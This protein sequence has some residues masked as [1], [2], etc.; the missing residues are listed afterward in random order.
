MYR[1]PSPASILNRALLRLEKKVATEMASADQDLDHYDP[2]P[3][4]PLITVQ[5]AE[6]MMPG[7]QQAAVK[8]TEANQ[9]NLQLHALDDAESQGANDL[10]RFFEEHPDATARVTLLMQE[11]MRVKELELAT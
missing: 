4:Y 6:T 11:L 9:G 2:D 7:L 8:A 5:E 1:W 3:E 10:E